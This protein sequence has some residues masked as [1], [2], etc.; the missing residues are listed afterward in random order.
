MLRKFSKN[1]FEWVS[2]PHE[3]KGK[4][5]VRVF[6]IRVMVQELLLVELFVQ[7]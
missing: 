1:L 4:F 3:K 7:F 2:A 5:V 6:L